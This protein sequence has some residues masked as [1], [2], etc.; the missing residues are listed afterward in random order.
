VLGRRRNA[1]AILVACILVALAY[2]GLAQPFGYRI[3]WAGVTMLFALGAAVGIMVFV[4]DT[5]NRE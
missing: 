1:I 5:G 4:L 2:G 3:E